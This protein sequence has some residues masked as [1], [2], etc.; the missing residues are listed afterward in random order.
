MCKIWV[1]CCEFNTIYWHNV[2]CYNA[3]QLH[4]LLFVTRQL[5]KWFPIFTKL[6]RSIPYDKTLQLLEHGHLKLHKMVPNWMCVFKLMFHVPVHTHTWNAFV[7]ISVASWPIF[8]QSLC[9]VCNVFSH[10][11]RICWAIDR[12]TGPSVLEHNSVSYWT[13]SMYGT[14]DKLRLVFL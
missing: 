10:W 3:T 6:D 5:M 8:F 12:K 7:A 14:E 13:K 1:V 4:Y 11:L 9:R 2:L